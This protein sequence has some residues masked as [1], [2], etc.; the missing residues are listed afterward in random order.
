MYLQQSHA[1]IPL[2]WT[3]LLISLLSLVH[4][5]LVTQYCISVLQDGSTVGALL[6]LSV[7]MEIGQELILDAKVVYDCMLS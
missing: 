3:M 7:K 2:M 4:G 6:S 5:F 1:N